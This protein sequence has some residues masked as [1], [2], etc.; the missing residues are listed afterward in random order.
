MPYHANLTFF[1]FKLTLYK[2]NI[3][4][5]RKFYF[6]IKDYL[7]L[8]IAAAFTSITLA[9]FNYLSYYIFDYIDLRLNANWQNVLTVLSLDL[10]LIVINGFLIHLINRTGVNIFVI[11][12]RIHNREWIKVGLNLALTFAT[13]YISFT[14]GLALGA[15]NA[16]TIIGGL[17]GYLFYRLTGLHKK[18]GFLIGAAMG[19]SIAL[20]NPFVGVSI[21]LESYD[22]RASGKNILKVIYASFVAY[23]FYSLLVNDYHHSSIFFEN[24]D[25]YLTGIE[26]TV[27]I[28]IPI[29]VI[30]VGYVFSNGIFL[31]KKLFQKHI[32][33]YVDF[34]L[35]LAIA[36]G[37]RF[38]YPQVLGTGDE[39]FKY[40]NIYEPILGLFVYLIVRYIF[41]LFSFNA[42]FNGGMVIPTLAFGAALGEFLVISTDS[43]FGFDQNQA[44]II[45]LITMLCF[46]AYVTGSYLTS[47]FLCFT[48]IHVQYIVIPLLFALLIT[49]KINSRTLHFDGISSI[50]LKMD[51]VNRYKVM[52]IFKYF[53]KPRLS[54]NDIYK[55]KRKRALRKKHNL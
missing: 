16:M 3:D 12:K 5:V 40:V 37:L 2:P 30:I 21:Y 6:Y 38:F 24:V 29:I 43:Y 1:Y 34:L 27:L 48:F 46:Y 41:I 14:L 10:C 7:V 42:N 17:L 52:P 25:E 33:E 23:L 39:F 49:Y 13:C 20:S 35:A 28:L 55:I 11:E 18:R 50:M 36:V 51:E 26:T 53:D 44:V 15:E 9:I 54:E 47:L 45:M 19:F 32:P 22:K 8:T 31:I 4:Y